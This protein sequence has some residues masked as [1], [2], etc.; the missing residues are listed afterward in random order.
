MVENLCQVRPLFSDWAH[1]EVKSLVWYNWGCFCVTELFCCQECYEWIR[2]CVT[3]ILCSQEHDLLRVKPLLCD[4]AILLSRAW[5]VTNEV[6]VVWLRYFAVKN[7]LCYEWGRCCVTELFCSQEHDLLRVKL[8]LCDWAIL[9]SKV[10]FVTSEFAVVWLRYF[11]VKS[12]ILLRMNWQ[13][14]DW[15]IL[16]TKVCFNT[17]EVTSEVPVVWLR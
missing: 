17:S 15:N 10:W 4:R 13:L 12:I 7:I 2:C 11:A 16:K 6:S 9:Q 14:C 1:F 3:E 5:F 8:L